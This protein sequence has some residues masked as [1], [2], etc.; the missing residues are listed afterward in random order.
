MDIQEELTAST[1]INITGSTISVD[2]DSDPTKNSQKP[3][4]SGGTKSAIDASQNASLQVLEDTVGWTGKNLLSKYRTTWNT[5]GQEVSDTNGVS[6]AKIPV[7]V[8]QQFRGS[9]KVA[10]ASGL[11]MVARQYDANGDFVSSA[12]V[13]SYSALN[14]IYTVPS[15]I[16]YIAV[17]QFSESGT[18]TKAWVDTNEVMLMDASI[19]DTSYEP[20][21]EDVKHFVDTKAEQWLNSAVGWTGKNLFKNVGQTETYK[22]VTYILNS[23]GSVS[24]S[25]TASENSIH[26]LGE[27]SL[28]AGTKII[29]SGCPSGGGESSYYIRLGKKANATDT[30]GSKVDTDGGNGVAV[31]I[32]ENSYGFVL[33]IGVIAGQNMGSKTFY[34]MIRL[35]SVSD[36]TFEPYHEDVDTAKANNSAIAPVIDQ[37]TAPYAIAQG[38]PFMHYGQFCI[39]KTYIAS[40]S[41]LVEDSNYT[42]EDVG[43]AI[44]LNNLYFTSTDSSI[45]TIKKV[46]A[47][48]FTQAIPLLTR[49]WM[50]CS[51]L[52]NVSGMPAICFTVFR[53]SS[54][55]FRCMVFLDQYIYVGKSISGT[56][57]VWKFTGTEES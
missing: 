23:N 24:T 31:T 41:T 51:G 15:G 20:Y 37:D 29:L 33:H 6:S 9:K 10:L 11:N 26:L 46:I 35:A 22:D 48:I 21:H 54:T 39:A 18:G 50:K 38:K 32:P 17:V 55:A 43:S 4:T 7:T 2:A 49:D 36:S 30:W 8:G 47:E 19:S 12:T 53:T 42:V 57:T 27:I 16:S 40:G 28:S 56:V 1:G 14:N 45:N 44:G 52:I 34:P 13:L 25:G 5:S 3:V